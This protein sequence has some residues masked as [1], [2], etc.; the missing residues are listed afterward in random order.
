MHMDLVWNEE[1]GTLTIDGVEY[2]SDDA[3]GPIDVRVP[4]LRIVTGRD[5]PHGVKVRA[6]RKVIGSSRVA[7]PSW[8][9]LPVRFAPP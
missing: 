3:D 1:E 7:G 8:R 6:V 5:L 9:F 2:W 4:A